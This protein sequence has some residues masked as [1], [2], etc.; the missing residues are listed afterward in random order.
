MNPSEHQPDLLQS[1]PVAGVFRALD[2]LRGQYH[3]LQRL[4]NVALAAMLALSLALNLFLGKQ[5][6]LV[7][8]K[9]RESRPV[10]QRLAAEFGRKEPSMQSFVSALQSYAITHPD[11][12][13]VLS[14]YTNA[15]PQFFANPVRIGGTMSGSGAPSSL[16]PS[17][18]PAKPPGR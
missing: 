6:R 7:R 2:E 12:Y 5:M 11:F 8:A 18:P 17:R 1:S 13:S 14:K 4:L 16:A 15:M 10:V 3:G 9:V